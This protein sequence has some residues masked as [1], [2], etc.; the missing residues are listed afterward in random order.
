MHGRSSI[1]VR[2][3]RAV[4]LV[5]VS[6]FLAHTEDVSQGIDLSDSCSG[7]M[8]MQSRY[9]AAGRGRPASLAGNRSRYL[10]SSMPNTSSGDSDQRSPGTPRWLSWICWLP[11]GSLLAIELYIRSFD[12]WGAWAAAPLLLIPGLI[13]LAV[14]IPGILGCV[15]EI[16]AGRLNPATVLCTL[17]ASLPIFWLGVRRFFM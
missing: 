1:E 6:D 15:T 2:A 4:L 11:L 9:Q 14:V 16:R 12:G 5:K 13:S 10:L 17:V 8:P 7:L 3:R